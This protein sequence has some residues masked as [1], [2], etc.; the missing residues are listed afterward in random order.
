MKLTSTI[1]SALAVILLLSV[2]APAQSCADNGENEITFSP[3]EEL[4]YGGQT[5]KLRI[6]YNVKNFL[7][8][9]QHNVIQVCSQ[10]QGGK[11]LRL[12]TCDD[13]DQAKSPIFDK[14]EVPTER[15]SVAADGLTTTK[16]NLRVGLKP[17]IQPR[18]YPLT[19]GFELPGQENA[20]P[21]RATFMLSVGDKKGLLKVETPP[22]LQEGPEQ[23]TGGTV[24]LF[25]LTLLNAYADYDV[26]ISEMTV[27]S[28]IER[29]VSKIVSSDPRGQFDLQRP[30]KIT[31][32]PPLIIEAGKTQDLKVTVK[33][34][35]LK[36][37][38]SLV[39]G[40]PGGASVNFKIKYSDAY[41]REPEPLRHSIPLRVSPN[42]VA[43]ITAVALG[44]AVAIFLMSFWKILKYEGTAR[45]RLMLVFSTALIG[46]IAT[47]LATQGQLNVSLDAFKLR[48]SH[49]MPLSLFVLSLFATVSGTP[50]LKK[51]FGVGG[52]AGAAAP[53]PS[54]GAAK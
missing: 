4:S 9:R 37:A 20:A 35:G 25:T 43:L 21:T 33:L 16:Y 45:Q 36:D 53:S 31:F 5:Y 51:F 26:S 13:C 3:L 48:A 12:V 44:V 39:T 42:S 2:P 49:D 50:L 46:L 24:K 54:T 38:G 15:S 17:D 18:N 30:D 28:N 14:V 10:T 23:A 1:L 7:A 47:I 11:N 29:L 52:S 32:E 19:L 6:G 40:F 27:D 8:G 34:G 22:Q 41:G